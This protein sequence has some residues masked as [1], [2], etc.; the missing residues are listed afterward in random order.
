MKADIEG[1]DGVQ[2]KLLLLHS[3]VRFLT[4]V[5]TKVISALIFSDEEVS[6]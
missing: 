2:S 6:G 4:M 5:C 3:I 1:G